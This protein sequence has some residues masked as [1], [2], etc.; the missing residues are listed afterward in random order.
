MTPEPPSLLSALRQS[1]GAEHERLESLTY[2]PKIMDG[3]LTAAEYRRLLEWQRRAHAVLEPQVGG[4]NRGTYAY[5]PR[6]E[7]PPGAGAATTDIPRAL[8]ILYVLEGGS[9]GGA[10]I[11]RK[12]RANPALQGEAPFSF[13]QQQ[14]EWGVPQWRAFTKMLSTVELTAGETERAVRGAKDAFGSFEAEW[15]A[16]P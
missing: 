10:V 8:G 3:S 12:L 13:Y 9:L 7:L 1:T 6:F 16:M 4:F 15:R 2:G 14:A 11:L 5:R